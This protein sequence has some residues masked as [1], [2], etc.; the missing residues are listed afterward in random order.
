[1]DPELLWKFL[2]VAGVLV[3]VAAVPIGGIWIIHWMFSDFP[4]LLEKRFSRKVSDS[5]SSIMLGFAAVA[6]ILFIW[7]ANKDGGH[8]SIECK[9]NWENC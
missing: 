8:V 9:Y 2:K 3:V 4:A 1:V 6:I 5:C 7:S